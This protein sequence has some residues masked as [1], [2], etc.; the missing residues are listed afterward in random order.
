MLLRFQAEK[1]KAKKKLREEVRRAQ[2]NQSNDEV[3]VPTGQPKA[4][5]QLP[6]T[7]P[8]DKH[9]E[10]GIYFATANISFQHIESEPFQR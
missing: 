6:L 4:P 7:T 5:K 10:L 9:L 2:G 8:I 3:M 1:E